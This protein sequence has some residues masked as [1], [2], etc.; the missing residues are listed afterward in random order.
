MTNLVSKAFF[1]WVNDTEVQILIV[2]Y[3]KD[4]KFIKVT[5]FS[6]NT[7]FQEEAPVPKRKRRYRKPNKGSS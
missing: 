6:G 5:D 1:H 3:N 7:V 4:G 2:N